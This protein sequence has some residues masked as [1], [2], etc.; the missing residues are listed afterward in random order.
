MLDENLP[1]FF[2]KPSSDN[3]LSSTLFLSQNGEELQPEYTLCVLIKYTNLQQPPSFFR[4]IF[5]KSED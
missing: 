1:T 5:A 3:P 2:T 4:A